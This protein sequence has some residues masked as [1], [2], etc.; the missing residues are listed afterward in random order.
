MAG[1]AP[2][3]AVPAN[4]RSYEIWVNNYFAQQ[5]FTSDELKNGATYR[6][7]GSTPTDN[8]TGAPPGVG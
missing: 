6:L 3:D 2:F 1:T 7:H 4:Q 5:S 8:N